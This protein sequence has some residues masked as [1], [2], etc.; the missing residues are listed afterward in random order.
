VAKTNFN[1]APTPRPIV[2]MAPPNRGLPMGGGLK[3]LTTAPTEPGKIPPWAFTRK[4]GGFDTWLDPDLLEMALDRDPAFRAACREAL[5]KLE[6]DPSPEK[7]AKAVRA[8]AKHA[9]RVLREAVLEDVA[10]RF[11]AV[12]GLVAEYGLAKE[13]ARRVSPLRFPEP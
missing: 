2:D 6:R 7:V 12:A 8:L 9:T 11:E 5:A 3:E 13:A 1:Y 4:G 10:L